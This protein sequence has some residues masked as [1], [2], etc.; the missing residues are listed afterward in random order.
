MTPPPA[1]SVLMTVYN[2]R[3]YLAQAVESVL[4]Q[5]FGDFEFIVIDDGSTDGSTDVLRD[6][7]ARDGRIRLISRRNTGMTRA[8]NEGIGV[9]QGRYIARMDADDICLPERFDRQVAYLDAHPDCVLL[10]SQVLLIDPDGDPLGPKH[11]TAYT[12]EDI[13]HS[14]LDKGWPMVHPA[15][16][17][18]T[19][20]LRAI[21][22]Y[23]ERWPTNQDHDLFT[24]LAEVGRVANLPE[25][26]L[27]YR[28]HFSSVSYTKG[29]EQEQTLLAILQAAYARRGRP[30]PADL[31]AQPTGGTRGDL[32]RKWFWLALKSGNIATARK[33]ARAALAREPR[34]AD[35]WK[36]AYHA[37]IGR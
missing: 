24:R 6:F 18:R 23:D 8:L 27:R 11:N 22:G 10:G 17:I 12:H 19:Q 30:M 15:V 28:Q 21:G 32:H 3:Q 36:V 13:E 34:R 33:H 5:T 25:V 2:G 20:A 37:V 29:L 4:S 14:L 9:A 1:V 7:T 26:L 16:M 31:K 35:S